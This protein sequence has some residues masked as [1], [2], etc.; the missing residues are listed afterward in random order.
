MDRGENIGNK[1]QTE[2]H[3]EKEPNAA[4]SV[5]VSTGAQKHKL[6]LRYNMIED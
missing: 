4:H 5:S 1:R 2:Q 6:L 3:Q